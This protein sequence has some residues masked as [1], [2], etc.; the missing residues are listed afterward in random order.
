M[1]SRKK[2]VLRNVIWGVFEKIVVLLL[3]F[4]IRTILIKV[5]GAQ[6][7]GLGSLFS[8]ILTVLSLSELGFGTAIV[9][10]MYKPIAEDDKQTICAL[11]NTF[12]KVYRIVGTIVLVVGI[13]ILPFIGYFI[14]GDTPADI[15]IYI[16]YSIYLLN[17]VI[18][19]FMFAYKAALFNAHQRNDIVSKLTLGVNLLG[20]VLQVISLLFFENYYMYIIVT[21]INTV[22]TNIAN[23]YL[24]KRLY[25]E[26]KCEGMISKEMAAGIKKR[27]IGLLSFK[28]YGVIFTAVD[29][30]VVSSFL[31][32]VTLAKYN[33][34]HYIQT[35][36][37]TFIIIFTNS[38]TAS[39]G[40]KMV[41][42]SIMDNYR[43]LKNLTFINAWVV[44]WCAICLVCLYQPFI[45]LWLG[46]D[47]L[48]PSS[49]MLL[50]VFQ[51]LFS[52]ISSITFT[53]RE[54]AGLWWEDRFRPLVAAIV[55]LCINL[56]LIRIIGIN[57]VIIATVFCTL[58]INIPWGT[59]ILFDKYFNKSP[60]EYFATLLNYTIYG[61]IVG[62]I[63]YNLTNTVTRD[64]LLSFV[65]RILICVS[66]PNVLLAILY[67]KRPE[68]I[69][70]VGL[71]IEIKNKV[72]RKNRNEG[73][74]E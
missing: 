23:A 38:L 7:L 31:G 39:I 70:S 56:T 49:T 48:L 12:R 53:Y 3:P 33:S 58:V 36:I 63:T 60:K 57:G 35:S 11:L 54:A 5:L 71:L 65:I 14:K 73:K 24:A 25:P 27:V 42:T 66:V 43:D 16:L 67:C 47:F 1:H 19:Y 52:R 34:Y 72:L 37:T 61:I 9:F 74:N 40:N 26:L 2:N 30:I 64:G 15:N 68:F 46:D 22:L 50:L 51:F 41:K 44:I 62:S 21:P 17:T 13:L 18:S 20:S 28:V 8:S 10:S 45:V 69:Y 29:T 6:Y 32:L 4:V 59:K 55:N